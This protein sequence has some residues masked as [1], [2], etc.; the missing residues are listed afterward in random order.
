MTSLNLKISKDITMTDTEDQWTED[1]SR[2]YQAIAPVAVPARAE[3]LAA[4]LTLLPF[5][6][7]DDFKV[8]EIG[9]GEGILSTCVLNC[10]PKA[11]VVALD[12]SAEMRHQTSRRL[13]HFSNRVTIASFDLYDSDWPSHLVNAD[14]VLSSL[15]V[16]HL[17]DEGKQTLFSTIHSQLSERGVLL[18]ADLIEAQRP[19]AK[20]LF[21][22]TWDRI[23]E[24]QSLAQTDSTELFELFKEAE[25]N[26]YRYHD[27]FDKPSYLFDQ[28]L[29][30]KEAGFR[31]VDCFWLQAGHAIYGGYKSA[32]Q[33]SGGRVSFE[34]ALQMAQKL[35]L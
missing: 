34:A 19:E 7:E 9:S 14:C 31:T 16:H 26:Y 27:P 20:A 11:S 25:W 23:T 6:R 33:P 35:L 29:W 18:L 8:V 22:A 30:L 4:L 3:Q 10:F 17:D 1:N 13:S 12:G 21:A 24:T 15:V 32:A 2:L 5:G 28:L